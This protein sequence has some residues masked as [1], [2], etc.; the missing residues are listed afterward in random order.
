[1]LFYW[2]TDE[3]IEKEKRPREQGKKYNNE[4]NVFKVGILSVNGIER[5]TKALCAYNF[6][7]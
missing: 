5:N 7:F 4:I 6:C 1:M 3:R 2:K